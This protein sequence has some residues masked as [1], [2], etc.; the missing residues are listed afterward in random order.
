VR[1]LAT[2]GKEFLQADKLL[3]DSPRSHLVRTLHA[4]VAQWGRAQEGVL[5]SA[6]LSETT[7]GALSAAG[8]YAVLKRFFAQAAKT[9]E[10]AGLDPRRFE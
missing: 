4:S 1:L 2:H 5:T 7:G 3:A 10:A 6:L 8:I 9:A